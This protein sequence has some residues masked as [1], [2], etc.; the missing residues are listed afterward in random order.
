MWRGD[1]RKAGGSNDPADVGLLRAIGIVFEAQG[2]PDLG[3]QFFGSWFHLGFLR[4]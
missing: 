1:E 3:E 4:P 2:I